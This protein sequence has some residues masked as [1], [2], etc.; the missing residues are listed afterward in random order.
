MNRYVNALATLASKIHILEENQNITMSI[1]RRNM[2][3]P[4][5]E[6]LQ[7]LTYEDNKS[8]YF[9]TLVTELDIQKMNFTLVAA[10]YYYLTKFY[11]LY[12]QL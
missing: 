6:L 5:S 1:I 11:C 8:N 3:C 4:G 12:S 10:L 9:S 7:S 2:S